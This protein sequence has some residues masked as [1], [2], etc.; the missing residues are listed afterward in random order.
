MRLIMLGVAACALTAFPDW[1]QAPASG[2]PVF[3]ITPNT[4]HDQVRS[5]GIGAD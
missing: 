4:K 1:A 2:V 3:K 5:E